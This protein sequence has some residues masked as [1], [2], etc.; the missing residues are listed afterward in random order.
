VSEKR[1]LEP[2]TRP[3]VEGETPTADH[4]AMQP[5]YVEWI[6]PL[7]PIGKELVRALDKSVAKPEADEREPGWDANGSPVP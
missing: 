7:S 6:D 2:S 4:P 3:L 5:G 1:R